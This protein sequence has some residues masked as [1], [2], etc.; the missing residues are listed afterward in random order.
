MEAAK[1]F[2]AKADTARIAAELRVTDR[3]VRRWRV[4]WRRGGMAALGSARP[5]HRCPVR[6]G[7]GRR[8]GPRAGCACSAPYD[9]LA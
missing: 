2:E 9:S 6:S 3:S 1:W 4:A 7:P 5:I 8:R